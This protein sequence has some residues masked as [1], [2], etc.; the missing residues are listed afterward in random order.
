[1][2]G[3]LQRASSLCGCLELTR[4]LEKKSIFKKNRVLAYARVNCQPGPTSTS[5]VNSQL[6]L[7]HLPVPR[8]K[9][10]V[11]SELP[12]SLYCTFYYDLYVWKGKVSMLRASTRGLG[13]VG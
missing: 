11:L 9:T 10:I 2:G 5:K 4:L 7:H 6:V 12:L 13:S 3:V 8:L 1:M